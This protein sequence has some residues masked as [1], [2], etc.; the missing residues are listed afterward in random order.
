MD[1]NKRKLLKWIIGA[2]MVPLL[3]MGIYLWDKIDPPEAPSLDPMPIY[4]QLERF[5]KNIEKLI[6]I[7]DERQRGLS[8]SKTP[9][10]EY[11]TNETPEKKGKQ[12]SA[13]T[14][15]EKIKLTNSFEYQGRSKFVV[16]KN[17]WK[18]TAY[19]DT[20][21]VIFDK[22]KYVVYHL[23]PTFSPN[24]IKVEEKDKGTHDKGF[25]L[26]RSGWGTFTI[27]ASVYIDDS[28]ME[29]EHYLFFKEQ[30]EDDPK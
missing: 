4:R 29:L 3:P 19:I 12:R 1:S 13:D 9:D 11:R 2:V 26:T 10:A 28:V 15:K 24:N 30:K 22:I 23:H 25:P 7:Y 20:E 16:G 5:N 21:Q 6:V 14:Y 27:K 8:G 17:V 18:W